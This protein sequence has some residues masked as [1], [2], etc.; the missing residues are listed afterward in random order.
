MMPCY[1]A[2]KS[3]PL[4]LAS[5]VAQGYEHWECLLVDDGSTDQPERVVRR[6]NDRRIT[7]IRLERNRGRGL[8]RQVALDRARG[9]LLCMLDAD[10]WLYPDKLAWQVEM[11]MARPDVPLVS[12]GMAIVDGAN[13]LLGVRR[14]GPAG[15][16]CGPLARLEPTP[17]AHGPSMIRM[18][19]ARQARYEPSFRRSEDTDFLLQVLLGRCYLV[20]P[21]ITYVY[22]EPAGLMRRRILEGYRYRLRLFWKYRRRFPL[23]SLR[24]MGQTLLKA[25][26]YGGAF[27]L[28]AEGRLLARRSQPPTTA[29]VAAFRRARRLVQAEAARLFG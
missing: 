26:V 24:Y 16:A 25:F 9:E 2:A 22:T 20:L 14:G 21:R 12:T 5:L 7:Y 10:D 19:V 15:E 1:N 8:A 4:A 13:H 17:V 23:D 27:A 11:M 18:A 3:L 6:V 28:G 29:E